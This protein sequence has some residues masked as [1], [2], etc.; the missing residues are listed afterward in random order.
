MCLFVAVL[1]NIDEL[2]DA[3]CV[4][5]LG[6]HIGGEVTNVK[7]MDTSAM[8]LEMTH[9]QLGGDASLYGLGATE[10]LDPCVLNGVGDEDATATF[11]GFMQ[12]EIVPQQRLGGIGAGADNRRGIV[13]YGGVDD[14]MYGRGK[15][16]VVS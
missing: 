5:V 13:W 3:R 16:L 7:R 4:T 10:L 14:G 1:N 2:G 11:R 12:L 15:H 9:E 8:Q 6:K